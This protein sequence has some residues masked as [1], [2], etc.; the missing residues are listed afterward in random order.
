MLFINKE[1][2]N[3]YYINIFH[4]K[5]RLLTFKSLLYK[6][7]KH[8]W[9]YFKG[10]IK[11]FFISFTKSLESRLFL[12]CFKNRLHKSFDKFVTNRTLILWQI[13]LYYYALDNMVGSQNLCLHAAFIVRIYMYLLTLFIFFVHVFELYKFSV[14]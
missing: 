10:T 1:Y 5:E 14:F 2:F 8:L 13:D 6:R 7:H 12:F 9:V 4:T 3:L 11:R